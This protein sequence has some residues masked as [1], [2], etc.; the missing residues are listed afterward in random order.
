[1]LAHPRSTDTAVLVKVKRISVSGKK[2]LQNKTTVTTPRIKLCVAW[3]DFEKLVAV[4]VQQCTPIYSCCEVDVSDL[5]YHS[6]FRESLCLL[7]KVRMCGYKSKVF[8]WKE[9]T[10]IEKSEPKRM[11]AHLNFFYHKHFLWNVV[12]SVICLDF[13]FS[14]LLNL[15][16]TDRWH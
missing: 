10:I 6:L 3:G 11:H 7:W 16:F 12:W 14:E 8:L 9:V 13:S 15:Y 5:M 2:G 1:M 4:G